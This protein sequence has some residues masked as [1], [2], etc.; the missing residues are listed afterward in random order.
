MF[1]KNKII[2]KQAKKPVFL[3]PN[4]RNIDKFEINKIYIMKKLILSIAFVCVAQL[5]MA[6]SQD[7]FKKDIIEMIK[8]SG[9]AGQMSIAKDQILTMISEDKQAD[10]IKEFDA[11]LPA[12]YDKMAEVYM[13]NYTHEDVKEMLKFYNTPIGK[14]IT[15]NSEKI[16]KEAMAASQ[17]WAMGLQGMMMKYAQ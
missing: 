11:T 17:E 14:K 10:F 9:S 6:Q 7:A 13:K 1:L 15:A 2:Q 3:F 4:L 8:A 12:L 5:G 16:T